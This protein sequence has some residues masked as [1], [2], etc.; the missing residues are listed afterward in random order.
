M[1]GEVDSWNLKLGWGFIKPDDLGPSIF[2][3][4]RSIH[5]R[6]YRKL[7][8]GQHVQY[9]VSTGADGK[10]E[11]INVTGLAGAYVDDPVLNT[12]PVVVVSKGKQ[13]AFK[14]RALSTK[15][16]GSAPVPRSAAIAAGASPAAV[17]SSSMPVSTYPA[18]VRVP[19]TV[20]TVAAE[21]VKADADSRRKKD[22]RSAG[23]GDESLPTKDGA[24]SL[25]TKDTARKKAR[26]K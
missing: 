8:L 5:S 7:D 20:S 14:P 11:A 9:E 17:S 15:N 19:A 4:H 24:E 10:P 3:H 18:P 16:V 22:K 26:R 25:P 1:R 21:S 13:L 6:G 23:G 2:V 12:L